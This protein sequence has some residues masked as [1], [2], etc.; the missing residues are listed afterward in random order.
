MEKLL[1]KGFAELAAT[2]SNAEEP[3]S[4]EGKLHEPPEYVASF[5][6]TNELV[7]LAAECGS[8]YDGWGTSVDEDR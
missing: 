4:V 5:K 7:R 6:V 3:W 8:E 1:E 2:P